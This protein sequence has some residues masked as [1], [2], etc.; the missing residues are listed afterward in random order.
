MN[1]YV[2]L[3][4]CG[5][6]ADLREFNDDVV[7][8]GRAAELH[9]GSADVGQHRPPLLFRTKLYHVE[10]VFS[11][12]FKKSYRHVAV[13][14][15]SGGEVGL[16]VATIPKGSSRKNNKPS[17]RVEPAEA[18]VLI[19]KIRFMISRGGCWGPG[20]VTTVETSDHY[21]IARIR[22][23]CGQWGSAKHTLNPL[24]QAMGRHAVSSPSCGF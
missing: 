24:A 15:A 22:E 8:V 19:A 12:G 2:S 10:A 20:I 18:A 13:G 7:G 9:D 6:G 16:G 11:T 5:S 17:A 4:V 1:V 14:D 21:Y 23:L 3:C